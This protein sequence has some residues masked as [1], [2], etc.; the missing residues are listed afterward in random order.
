MCL[1][2]ASLGL[3]LSP[4]GGAARSVENALA[5]AV[6]VGGER[7]AWGLWGDLWHD[8][9]SHAKYAVASAGTA[10]VFGDENMQGWPCSSACD[11]SQ[12]GRGGTFFALG[13][14]AL[15]ASLA[16]T[17]A[18]VARATARAADAAVLHLGCAAQQQRVDAEPAA[19]MRASAWEAVAWAVGERAAL[20]YMV[21]GPL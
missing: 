8:F 15:R 18:L 11:R 3:A 1:A 7:R 20:F 17:M 16:A 10:A 14:A 12:N 6:D 21:R 9:T 5:A 19:T 2:D 13:D 4:T